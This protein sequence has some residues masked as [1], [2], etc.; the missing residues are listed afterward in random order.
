MCRRASLRSFAKLKEKLDIQ[1]LIFH[2]ISSCKYMAVI[3][4][5]FSSKLYFLAFLILSIVKK[6]QII[7][8]RLYSLTDV[9]KMMKTISAKY[10]A[11]DIRY[12]IIGM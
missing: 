9:K 8:I 10:T 12:K 7:K 4:L 1:Y 11:K 6:F 3:S 5:H 2:V